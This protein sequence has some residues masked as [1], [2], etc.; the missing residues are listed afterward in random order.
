VKSEAAPALVTVLMPFIYLFIYLFIFMIIGNI[1]YKKK[2][3]FV[4]FLKN[5]NAGTYQSYVIIYTHVAVFLRFFSQF[6][7]FRVG[8]QKIIHSKY[9]SNNAKTFKIVHENFKIALILGYAIFFC[10]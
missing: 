2:H 6:G 5:N 10:I 7:I 3:I 4:H 1:N 8:N 9:L